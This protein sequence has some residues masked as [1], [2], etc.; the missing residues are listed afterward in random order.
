[1]TFKGRRGPVAR[2]AL[3]LVA[4]LALAA[5]LAP[6]PLAAVIRPEAR[7]QTVENH[8]RFRLVGPAGIEITE[9]GTA[10][11]SY[12]GPATTHLTFSGGKMTGTWSQR[13]SGGTVRGRTNATIVGRSAQ[14]VV[15]FSGTAKITGGTGRFA[16]ASGTLRLTGTIRRS[17]YAIYEKTSGRV[18]F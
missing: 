6:G 14:P 4:C 2:G 18:H 9:K 13:T 3:V 7:R 16:S 10:I 12:P 17:N 11:G 15:Q 5:A 8:T 1:M